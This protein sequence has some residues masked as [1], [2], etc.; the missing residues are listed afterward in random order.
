MRKLL[1]M[2]ACSI[3]ALHGQWINTADGLFEEQIMSERPSPY[4]GP[5]GQGHWIYHEQPEFIGMEFMHKNWLLVCN[6]TGGCSAVGYPEKYDGLPVSLRFSRDAGATAPLRGQLLLLQSDGTAPDLR[7]VQL[8]V[9][10]APQGTIT[11]DRAGRA[12]L[13][14]EMLEKLRRAVLG[15]ADIIFSGG[16]LRWQLANH[17]ANLVLHRMDI[18]Q[19]RDGTATALVERGESKGDMA[20]RQPVPTI[21]YRPLP[22]QPAVVLDEDSTEHRVLYGLL[23]RAFKQRYR[24]SFCE[25]FR[26]YDRELPRSLFEDFLE[27]KRAISLYRLDGDKYLLKTLCMAFPGGGEHD[28]YHVY[29]VINRDKEQVLE[30]VGD[31]KGV[32][33]HFA[34][35]FNVHNG[36]GLYRIGRDFSNCWSRYSYHWDGEHF[37]MGASS[38]SGFCLPRLGDAWTLPRFISNLRRID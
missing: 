2:L 31:R 32:R 34:A 6:N 12:Q 25:T 30:L 16:K 9:G 11:L 3:N 1:L 21:N 20:E 23:R 35:T 7:E 27:G 10:K 26:K 24:N 22:T 33:G 29:A 19:G 17:G 38:T 15:K 4:Y 37:Q 13:S 18:F 8:Q 28:Q 5:D 36:Q 14:E